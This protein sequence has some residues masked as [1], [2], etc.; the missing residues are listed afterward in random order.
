[1]E[2]ASQTTFGYLKKEF[3]P[4]APFN[5]SMDIFI[6]VS[7]L[8]KVVSVILT[9]FVRTL[10]TQDKESRPPKFRKRTDANRWFHRG[11]VI[12]SRPSTS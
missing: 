10:R 9:F 5:R 6:R 11:S 12:R 7:F 1:V 4:Y 3:H 2:A 8:R